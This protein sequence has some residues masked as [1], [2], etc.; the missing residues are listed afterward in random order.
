MTS[1]CAVSASY[2]AAR[3]GPCVDKRFGPIDVLMDI[4]LDLHAGEGLCLL[5]DNGAGKSTVIRAGCTKLTSGVIATFPAKTGAP[6]KPS[7]ELGA[8]RQAR[9]RALPSRQFD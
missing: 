8:A 2:G 7:A 5:G 4:S 3:A 1:A 6:V 9:R